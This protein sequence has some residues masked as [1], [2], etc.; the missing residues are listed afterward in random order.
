MAA[1]YQGEEK[2][3][4]QRM[5]QGQLGSI[6]YSSGVIAPNI[7]SPAPT[8]SVQFNDTV[9]NNY[10][11]VKRHNDVFALHTSG[12][13]LGSD[14]YSFATFQTIDLRDLIRDQAGLDD[15]TINVQRQYELPFPAFAFNVAPGNIEECLVMI[16]GD[17]NMERNITSVASIFN[18]GFGNVR[19]TSGGNPFE[20]LYREIRQ[21]VQDPSQNFI[22]PDQI[23]SYA[24]P[25]GDATQ[26]P[27][28]FTANL[29]LQSRTIG[30]Y[31]DLVVGPAITVIRAWRVFCA[32]RTI[33]SISGGGL[34]DN[35][36]DEMV[37]L[38]SRLDLQI[39]ALQF[40]IVG[41]QRD[42]TDTEIAT[43]YSNILQNP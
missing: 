37:Y 14:G 31:P 2:V 30:G 8:A 16:L 1:T 35:P 34:T 18:A 33:Q 20:V 26:A 12:N 32:D 21:Y 4:K 38:Q 43:Y 19:G 23:G 10:M 40:N 25:V 17:L 28:R 6:T 9:G 42:L 27:T 29:R 11:Y 7:L 22:S 39:P 3:S 13:I 15:V 24:G 36:A 41:T 5:I